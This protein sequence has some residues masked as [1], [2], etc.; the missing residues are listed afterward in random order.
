MPT[1]LPPQYHKIEDKYKAAR[2]PAEKM[3]HLREMMSIMPR[4]KGTDKIWGEHR[5]KLSQLQ[6]QIEQQKT[7]KSGGG[8]NPWFVQ[9]GDSPQVLLLGAPNSGRSSVVA[10][11]THAHA[12]VAEF[13][14]STSLPLPGMM[15]YRDVQIELVDTP[16]VANFPLD[17]WI[18]DQTRSAD[19]LVVFVDLSAEDCC[20]AAMGI[21][22]GLEER[23][24]FPVT[25]PDED[26]SEKAL[27]QRPTLL[28]LN[29][30]DHPDAGVNLE[31]V[32]EVIGRDLPRVIFSAD[33]PEGL[34]SF[35][36]AVWSLLR[37]VRVYTKVPGK[38]AV[39]EA[40]YMLPR[41]STILDLAGKVH[42]DFLE[43]FES[44]KVWGS[45]KFDGQTV[46]REH[47][48]EDDDIVEIQVK[49]G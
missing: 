34:E 44:A 33:R 25:W 23:S 18:L 3:A 20:E 11:L 28:A 7:S 31:F 9:K 29:K 42:R 17:S 38:K 39:H 45:G 5:K 48:V 30:A 14:F 13:P 32:D 27:N 43:Q 15:P 26:D 4:H 22:E 35:R 47:V 37:M 46:D 36:E 41:G 2:D 21:L 8:H 10:G 19:A 16:P 12:V 6:E 49:S 1:N 40:P 24:L